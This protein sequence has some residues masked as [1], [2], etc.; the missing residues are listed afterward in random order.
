MGVYIQ[1]YYQDNNVVGGKIIDL[2]KVK[3]SPV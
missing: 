2:L 3:Y 1:I